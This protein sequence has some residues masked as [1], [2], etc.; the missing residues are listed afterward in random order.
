M[1]RPTT[2]A[3]FL[4]LLGESRLIDDVI[5]KHL[6]PQVLD[7][8]SKSSQKPEYAAR[9][10]Y[11]NNV[12]TSYQAR[13]LMAGRY[14]GF[15]IAKYKFMELLGVGGM[16]KVY[17]AEQITGP[18]L[19]VIKV[20]RTNFKSA[21]QKDETFARF[22]REAEAVARLKH[23]NIIKAI[24]YDH[25]NGI[26]YFVMEY[27]EGIDLGQQVDRFGALPWA[28][29]AD[30]ILQAATALQHAHEAEMVHR[31]VKPQNLLVSTSG[32][33]KLLDLGLVSPFE[34]TNDDSLTTA[35][36][37]IGSVDYIAPEQ[38][39]DSR[40]VDPRAD[41]YGLGATFYAILA[42]QVLYPDKTTAQK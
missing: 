3:E 23:P 29:A 1:A 32:E 33:V 5:L 40:F 11:E 13:Q 41:I 24:E 9:A 7:P 6:R 20:V 36:N 26:P 38:S 34:G 35:E 39:V 8:S 16:G 22:R 10:L 2:S 15:Y 30:N 28:H 12:I 17:L 21:I 4:D 18:R 37:Q 27:V 31:D 25:E 42:G 14:R 19:V